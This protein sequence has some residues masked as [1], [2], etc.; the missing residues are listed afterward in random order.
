MRANCDGEGA[1]DV[2]FA[3]VLE[4]AP[5][6][7]KPLLP[8][9]VGQIGGRER[10]CACCCPGMF[11]AGSHRSY[12]AGALRHAMTRSVALRCGC[13]IQMPVHVAWKRNSAVRGARS[14]V[15]WYLS[16]PISIQWTQQAMPTTLYH[17]CITFY[18]LYSTSS[19][20]TVSISRMDG[21]RAGSTGR[22][23]KQMESFR[24]ITC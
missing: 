13:S 5:R 22:M 1:P 19:E 2:C 10:S 17:S 20:P 3:E 12:E 8:R 24:P 18:N 11:G 9:S 6:G 14:A 23:L 15:D 16:Y 4:T 21:A 7:L